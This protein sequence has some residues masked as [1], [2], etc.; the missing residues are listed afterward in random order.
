MK[1]ILTYFFVALGI[2]FFVILI[3]LSY[4]WFADPF[5]IRPLIKS[6]TQEIPATQ[7]QE[8][9]QETV[10]AD[11]HPALTEEQEQALETIGIDPSALPTTIT[12]EMETCFTAV[13]GEERVQ[14]IRDGA[15]PT[16]VEAF[17]TREC[18]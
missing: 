3:G 4:L 8:S 10:R 7:S 14:E 12:P 16:P 11:K 13:L 2:I 6:L 18:Y 5:E 9:T 17:K 15:S 1:K